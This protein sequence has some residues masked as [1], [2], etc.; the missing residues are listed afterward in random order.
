MNDNIGLKVLDSGKELLGV[1]DVAL[2]VGGGR[3]AVLLAAQID[4]SDKG[5][6][7]GFE[8]LVHDVVAQEAVTT[9]NNDS[10]QLAP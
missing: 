9:D 7:P 1:G 8:G 2:A 6:G 5:G 10:A 4:G 3:I